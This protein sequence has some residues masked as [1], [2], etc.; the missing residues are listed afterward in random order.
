MSYYRW[1]YP[2]GIS[3]YRLS[4]SVVFIYRFFPFQ[5]GS[6]VIQGCRQLIPHTRN[7]WSQDSRRS[8]E[9]CWRSIQRGLTVDFAYVI[10]PNLPLGRA[11]LWSDRLAQCD[12]SWLLSN[13]Q[14]SYGRSKS[15][16]YSGSESIESFRKRIIGW[17][18]CR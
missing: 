13:I 3:F 17:S 15:M 14:W 18:A 16:V 6:G 2:I 11:I 8:V 9:E 1:I 7:C 12:S 10:A 5:N 4:W